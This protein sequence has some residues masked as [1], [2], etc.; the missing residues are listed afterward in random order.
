MQTATF[1]KLTML[2]KKKKAAAAANAADAPSGN[3][4][5]AKRS[6]N[7]VNDNVRTTLM[8]T[9]VCILFLITEFPQALLTF[10]NIV[11]GNNFYE[12]V[13]MPLGDLVDMITLFNTSI[14]F[15]LYCT[16]SR[17]F[18]DTFYEIIKRLWVFRDRGNRS[19]T[20]KN[21]V[22]GT[23]ANGTNGNNHHNNNNDK[24][25]RSKLLSKN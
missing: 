2:K 9:T 3:N 24:T 4:N 25:Q 13:Y 8:L 11:L 20:H 12:N 22:N 15:L 14:S 19:T 21:A 17:Q 5:K 7:R 10:F 1:V 23:S 18:R 16:M 6:K